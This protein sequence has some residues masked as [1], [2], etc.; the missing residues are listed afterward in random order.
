M[1]FVEK[2]TFFGNAKKENIIMNIDINFWGTFPYI[3][4]FHKIIPISELKTPYHLTPYLFNE[5][6][7]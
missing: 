2:Y 7:N 3:K 1:D 4:D 5:I 6:I